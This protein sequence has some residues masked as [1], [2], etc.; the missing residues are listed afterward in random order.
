MVAGETAWS[1]LP[2]LILLAVAVFAAVMFFPGLTLWVRSQDPRRPREPVL[3][4]A[5][6]RQLP[7]EPP[8]RVH[9]MAHS[10]VICGRPLTNPQSMRARVGSTCIQRYGPRYKMIPN[11][12]HEKWRGL[13][14]SA[15]ADRAAEQARL[16]VAHQ[17]ALARHSNLLRAW[18]AERQTPAA[19]ARRQTRRAACE[20]MLMGAAATPFGT[21]LGIAIAL[22]LA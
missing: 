20:R 6:L 9:E 8:A 22:P 19:H 3:T 5:R 12:Q 7:P 2:T 15:E 4:R 14:A 21:L 13:L 18:E 17:Q 16:N 11:P 1:G 10:C